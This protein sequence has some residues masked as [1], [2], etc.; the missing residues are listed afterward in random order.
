MAQIN[1][2]ANLSEKTICGKL[3]YIYESPDFEAHH[4]SDEN[5]PKFHPQTLTILLDCSYSTNNSTE[6]NRHD[7]VEMNRNADEEEPIPTPPIIIAELQ[8][9]SILLMEY[10]AKY[11]FTGAIVN[12]ISF[13]NK[14]ECE[15]FKI[16]SNKDMHT[17]LIV[18]LDNIH[19][20]YQL[21]TNLDQPLKYVLNNI[22]KA[23]IDEYS[24][25]ILATDGQPNNKEL[26]YTLLNRKPLQKFL[27][28]V[29]GAGSIGNSAGG[30][31]VFSC[32]KGIINPKDYVQEPFKSGDNSI[33]LFGK[34][35]QEIS[36]A[37]HL[38]PALIEKIKAAKETYY[39]NINTLLNT[40]PTANM[41]E[42]EC[43][44]NYLKRLIYVP[45]A[46]AAAYC[47][48]YGNNSTLKKMITE[49]VNLCLKLNEK[50]ITYGIYLD[51]SMFSAYDQEV[52]DALLKDN[53]ILIK[54][55]YGSYVITKTWQCAVNIVD[56]NNL[57]SLMY[58]QPSRTIKSN[59]LQ[60]TSFDQIAKMKPVGD[61][62]IQ[63]G[64]YKIVGL[65][66]TNDYYRVREVIQKV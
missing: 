8:G 4:H 23:D 59:V 66:D 22:H 18:Q 11:D 28:F 19:E 40:T 44:V 43:D 7:H 60:I 39:K 13:S 46:T 45:T 6:P 58:T 25:I 10:L 16:V 15:P 62:N 14:F 21:C 53:M 47:G 24:H 20:Y 51:N 29:V 37:D 36:L 33:G 1:K 50:V 41:T 64:I 9:I 12:F 32:V 27:L 34:H 35:L 5:K 63:F 30:E 48:S 42:A 17:R 56:G 49:W 61:I 31:S 55:P 38:I 54:K 57:K 3:G 52:S 26:V 2:F 65:T